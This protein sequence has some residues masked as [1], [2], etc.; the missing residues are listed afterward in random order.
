MRL[1]FGYAKLRYRGLAKNR[2]RIELLL[3]FSNLLIAGRS[4]RGETRDHCA[5]FPPERRETGRKSTN[6]QFPSRFRTKRKHFSARK[7]DSRLRSACPAPCGDRKPGLIR[8]SLGSPPFRV[9]DA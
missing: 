4:P 7:M 6:S 1:H 3:G 5:R 2:Q 8:P 9:N